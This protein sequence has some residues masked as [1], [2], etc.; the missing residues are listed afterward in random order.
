[1]IVSPSIGP[2]LP[3]IGGCSPAW[4]PDGAI[5]YIRRGSIVE[6]PRTGRAQ[7]LRSR[8]Q[9]ARALERRLGPGAWRV[10][11]VAWLGSTR[12]AVLAAT[13][14]RTALVVFAGRRITSV[15]SKIPSPVTELRASPR[16]TRVLL[17]TPAGLYLYDV[18]QQRLRRL[19]G[20]DAIAWSSDER[21]VATG[22]SARVVL[23]GGSTRIVLPLGVVDLGWTRGI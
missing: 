17:R 9:L 1:M 2:A 20:I 16:G 14:S 23:R 7:V 18:G 19:H 3:M 12:F 21:W 4:R 11:S 6:F 13:G 10:G 15:E 22:S 8:E 5:S